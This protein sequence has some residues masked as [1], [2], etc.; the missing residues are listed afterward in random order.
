MEAV[1]N[2]DSWYDANRHLFDPPVCNKLMFK[3]QL[4]VM[5][6][7]GPNVRTDFHLDQGSEFFWMVRGNM[8]LP[9]IQRGELKRVTIREGE[10]FLLPSRVPHS[11]Q[12]PEQGSLGLVVERS[13]SVSAVPPELDGLRWYTDFDAPQQILY[14]KFFH[15]DDLGRDLVPVVKEFHASEEK[16]TGVPGANICT[17]ETRPF[18]Q[19]VTTAVPDP[20][21]LEEWISA[22]SHELECGAQLDLFNCDGTAHPDKEFKIYVCGGAADG[23]TVTEGT[24]GPGDTWL[25]QLRG[26]VSVSLHG[27]DATNS[28]QLL[29]KCGGVIPPNTPFKV[30][31]S[32]CSIGFVIANDPMGNK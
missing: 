30:T 17:D 21:N 4:S 8:E 32:P 18:V 13:R 31:R 19:D 6:V 22:H 29:A 27:A 24:T 26:H 3:K 10:V 23:G 7:G 20:F 5:F 12:R 9:T 16:R 15:C 28:Q 11:P 25:F 1:Y 14:E 2:L